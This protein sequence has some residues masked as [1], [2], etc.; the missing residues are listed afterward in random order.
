MLPF[1]EENI[2]DGPSFPR[3]ADI[4][5]DVINATKACFD[6]E[7]KGAKSTVVQYAEI[8]CLS[9][10]VH[11]LVGPPQDVSVQ[12]EFCY[13]PTHTTRVFKSLLIYPSVS[14]SYVFCLF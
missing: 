13:N 6:A 14:S 1:M 10:A 12:T 5:Y 3:G 7:I 9:F 11:V 8:G 4:P 2:N